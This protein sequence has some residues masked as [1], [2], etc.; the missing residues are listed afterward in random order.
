MRILITNTGPWGTG[1][2]TVA[3]A[4]LQE[5]L[6]MGHEVIL[7]F[8]DEKFPSKDIEEYYSRRDI[9]KI[10]KF[11]LQKNCFC[12]SSFP[13]I[14]PDP[15]PR[16]S[17]GRTFLELSDEELEFYFSEFRQEITPLI[18]EFQPDIIECQHLWTFD[19]IIQEFDIPFACSAHHSDQMG[20]RYD[21][22]MRPYIL[23][24][25]QKAKYIFAVSESVK[26]EVLQLYGAA[27]EK[28][29][30]LPNGFDK[31]IFHPMHLNRQDI[32]QQLDVN[33][34]SDAK[35][36][37]FC[38]KISKTKGIDILLMAN[39]LLSDQ[40]NIH[41][42]IFGAGDI[43][44]ALDLDKEDS[45]SFKNIHFLGHQP[46]EVL[47]KAHNIADCSVMP[48][49]SE[50][51]GIAILEAIGCGCPAIVTRCGGPENFAVGRVV[52]KEN[53]EALA[54]ALVEIC[55]LSTTERKAISRQ[56]LEQSHHYSWRQIAK[57]RLDYYEKMVKMHKAA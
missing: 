20:F 42:L 1:S 43:H 6:D 57:H 21:K 41:F 16:N 35:I 8:P 10:W 28:V 45:Y 23:E 36:I 48:S 50:G 19:H 37:S 26:E 46:P 11:P 24:S 40:E 38:G 7:F 31:R 2:F 15:H 12:I 53:P 4:I 29:I 51:F 13:L 30:V 32:L 9:Y 47:A 25:S 14:I 3:K 39:K 17:V 56:A 52:E 18:E 44:T 22:R 33:I 27:A 5:F 34:P 49:R 55:N 54:N